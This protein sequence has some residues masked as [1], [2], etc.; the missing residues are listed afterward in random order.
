MNKLL[1]LILLMIICITNKHHEVDYL[2]PYKT[3]A[4]LVGKGGI[5]NY[6]GIARAEKKVSRL[7]LDWKPRPKYQDSKKKWDRN[8]DYNAY[9]NAQR[10]FKWGWEIE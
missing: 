4:Y 3:F 1:T 10:T 2:Y 9:F 6:F 5:N 8:F 7:P